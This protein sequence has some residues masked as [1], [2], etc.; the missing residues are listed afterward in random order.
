MT[1][2]E[3]FVEAFGESSYNNLVGAAKEANA[4]DIFTWLLDEY[5]EP[6]RRT[7]DII[8]IDTD[9]IPKEEPKKRHYRGS[10]TG[11]GYDFK[12]YLDAVEDFYLGKGKS[13]ELKMSDDL[14]SGKKVKSIDGFKTRWQTA[15]NELGLNEEIWVHKYYAGT[16]NECICLEKPN[17]KNSKAAGF[18]N[19]R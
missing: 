14:S 12:W 17:F 5:K 13:I 16:C 6:V 2:K 9:D 11:R 10:L 1:N 18:V 19:M 15:V 8:K 7:D 4:I 3:K